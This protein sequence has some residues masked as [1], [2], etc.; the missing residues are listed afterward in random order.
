MATRSLKWTAWLKLMAKHGFDSD[1][2]AYKNLSGMPPL[3]AAKK[4]GISKGRI[5]QL[6]QEE[7]LDTLQVTNAAGAVCVTLVTD[8]SLERYLA[9]R[10]PVPGHQGHFSFSPN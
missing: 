1:E 8:A 5:F 9:E 10:V 2:S 6:I 3:D 7:K 4:L